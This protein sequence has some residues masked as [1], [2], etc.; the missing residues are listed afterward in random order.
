MAID[1]WATDSYGREYTH[2]FFLNKKTTTLKLVESSNFI[3]D[4]SFKKEKKTSVIGSLESRPTLIESQK[5]EFE[6][7]HL[8]A[9]HERCKLFN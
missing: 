8:E 9:K 6:F 3:R 4:Y 7:V 5:K 1:N 2:V